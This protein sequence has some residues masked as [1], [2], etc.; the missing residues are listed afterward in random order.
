MTGKSDQQVEE[1]LEILTED[2]QPE[3]V[4][5]IRQTAAQYEMTTSFVQRSDAE[6]G[7]R[8]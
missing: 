7:G 6:L 8:F 1:F 5:L 4:E 3:V 2:G